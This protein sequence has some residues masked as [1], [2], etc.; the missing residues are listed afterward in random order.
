[1]TL[2][3]VIAARDEEQML[4]G[5][6]RLLAF[7][8]EIV[9]VVDSRSS[10]RTEAIAREATERVY[11]REFDDFSAQK[12]FGLEQASGDWTLVVDADERIT[13]ALAAEIRSILATDPAESAFEIERLNFFLGRPMRHG[14]WSE[15]LVRLVRTSGAR[16]R[17][18]IHETFALDEPV[19]RLREPM[20]HF[21]HRSIEDMLEK[22]VT[23]GRV[24]ARDLHAGGAPPVTAPR[25]V[26]TILR[27]LAFRMVR[28]RG[29]RDG[30]PGVIE[31]LYQPFSLFC[32]RVMLWQLQQQPSLEETYGRL[33]QRLLDVR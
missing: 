4:P 28:R 31:A 30:L 17:N 22:T 6:L 2:S 8:D 27:E 26:A 14:G 1:M 25:L 21:S 24:Q 10:D 29:Y 16:Y 23:F 33:E 12:N 9:V 19:G 7:A 3:A 18:A 11:V 32:V 15:R 13:P 20:W 5:C